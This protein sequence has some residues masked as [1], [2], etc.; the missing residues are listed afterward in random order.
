MNR[1]GLVVGP[2]VQD[3]LPHLYCRNMWST[4]C[5]PWGVTL[6][7]RRRHLWHCHIRRQRGRSGNLGW[8]G[9]QGSN[10]I[11]RAY[12]YIYIHT[13]TCIILWYR[14]YIY[15]YISYIESC[16]HDAVNSVGRYWMCALGAELR[17][18]ISKI[19]MWPR[20]LSSYQHVCIPELKQH[21][22]KL[23]WIPSKANH[24]LMPL[25]TS[26]SVYWF[27]FLTDLSTQ[28]EKNSPPDG[29]SS[30]VSS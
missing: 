30:L 28:L 29:G 7:G 27:R 12:V 15:I 2:M 17:C 1:V 14:V 19:S 21:T 25:L 22:M 18:C 9:L 10:W 20:G 8:R 24:Q 5:G 16:D 13:Y 3:T 4:R 23:L 11:E 6:P 26:K